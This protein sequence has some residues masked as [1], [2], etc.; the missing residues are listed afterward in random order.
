MSLPLPHCTP[1]GAPSLERTMYHVPLD[2]R[3]TA[4][5]AFPSVV[6]PRDGNVAAVAPLHTRGRA[7]GSTVNVGLIRK[8]NRV[9]QTADFSLRIAP[10]IDVSRSI[11]QPWRSGTR[12]SSFSG[13]G[14][15][16]PGGVRF[17][18]LERFIPQS[19]K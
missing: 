1:V 19:R 14:D 13:P 7:V 6:V 10:W 18:R 12:S 5:S 16:H 11:D 9:T 4:M 17:A 3:D 8:M 2:G 15:G